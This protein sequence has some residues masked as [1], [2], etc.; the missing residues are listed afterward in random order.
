ML[1]DNLAAA[2]HQ[3]EFGQWLPFKL[4]LHSS[5]SPEPSRCW[6][7]NFS[8]VRTIITY[9]H[10]LLESPLKRYSL[11]RTEPASHFRILRGEVR[12][13]HTMPLRRDNP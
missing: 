8:P 10:S 4:V 7:T 1:P 12:V 3:A 2:C 5:H 11:G 9:A 6:H 13:T